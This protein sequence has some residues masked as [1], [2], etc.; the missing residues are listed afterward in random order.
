[1]PEAD[2]GEEQNNAD[3]ASEVKARRAQTRPEKAERPDESMKLV[4][5]YSVIRMGAGRRASRKV[6]SDR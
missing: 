3:C 2:R 4:R 1:M 6:T 5:H